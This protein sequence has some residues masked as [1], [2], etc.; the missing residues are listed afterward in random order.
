MLLVE[1]PSEEDRKVF[2]R[3]LYGFNH[4]DTEA[5]D[6]TMC[7]DHP[8]IS[9][10]S[11]T[12]NAFEND[13]F[14]NTILMLRKEYGPLKIGYLCT[15][16]SVYRKCLYLENLG[17]LELSTSRVYPFHVIIKLKSVK[18]TLFEKEKWLAKQLISTDEQEPNG[19][20]T[21]FPY[22]ERIKPLEPAPGA[23]FAMEIDYWA[24]TCRYEK[25]IYTLPIDAEQENCKIA[26]YQG[27]LFT[28]EIWKTMK[29]I[30]KY[31]VRPEGHAD[32]YR[33]MADP[34][35]LKLPLC[36]SAI[37]ESDQMIIFS[38]GFSLTAPLCCQESIRFF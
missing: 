17:I 11:D 3:F 30:P 26:T 24:A 14:Y 21:Y 29:I 27:Y 7:I 25:G 38:N 19:T 15:E 6:R 5:F 33:M 32:Y 35:S 28:D 4:Q 9:G 23:R 10:V 36:R 34:E 12:V 22:I 16:N 8:R 18:C 2:W 31:T 1:Y 13:A 20:E 37:E